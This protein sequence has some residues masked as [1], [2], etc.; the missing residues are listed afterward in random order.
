[1]S[2]SA[3]QKLEQHYGVIGRLAGAHAL[4][5]WD[6]NVV[7]RAGAAPAHGEIAG[8]MA[9]I[10]AEKTTDPRIADWLA[11]A[12][13]GVDALNPWQA[14]NLRLIVRAYRHATAVPA[15]LQIE[16]ATH[17]AALNRTWM[18]A[19][20]DNNFALFA[21]GLKTLL[22]IQ[23][24]IAGRKGE[25]L[26]LS[27][28]DAL[29]DESD[30]GSTSAMV[31]RVFDPLRREL[32][33]LLAEVLERQ[34]AWKPLPLGEHADE[35]Q[36]EL[37]ESVM[38]QIGYDFN[39]GR[40]DVTTHPFALANVPGDSRIATRFKADDLRFA[41]MAT[42]HETGHSFYEFNLPRD[43]SFQPVG[44]ALSASLHESQ[45]LMLEMQACRSSEFIGFIAPELAKRFGAH[46]PAFGRDN[47]AQHYHRIQRN[48]IRIEADEVVYPLHVI[49]R[50]DIERS[51]LD[52]TLAVNDLPEAWN[53]KMQQLVG[54]VPPTDTLGCLQDVHW[55]FGMFGYFPSYSLGAATAAQ[56]FEAATAADPTILPQIALGNFKPYF[57]W[58]RVNVHAK[59]SRVSSE[60]LMTQ[61]TGRALDA[62]AL[63]RHLRRRYLGA[64]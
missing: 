27:P 22:D 20:A 26:G 29:M 50:Y 64:H 32:P 62:D 10:L 57:D 30:P 23:R 42:I 39:S 59:A 17:S 7:M 2:G 33:G 43:W 21:P 41:L 51:L 24:E 36:R 63:L 37:N 11:Q 5:F 4:L 56:L 3:Y 38:R 52:G 40:L 9:T 48:L 46:D 45:S 13:D 54:V 49:L 55:S 6:R 34:A 58:A 28:Y 14:T 61:A 18:Q 60:T 12:Q 8:A 44:A 25:A 15:A 53:A 31:D 47:V 16:M 19:R 1:M 35:A